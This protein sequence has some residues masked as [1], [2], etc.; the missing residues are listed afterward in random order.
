MSCVHGSQLLNCSKQ[1]AIGMHHNG[2]VIDQFRKPKHS[3][4]GT[5]KLC[6]WRDS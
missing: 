4:G 2:Q 3:V 6:T 1:V 5:R